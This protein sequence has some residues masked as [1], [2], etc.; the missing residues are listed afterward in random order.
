MDAPNMRAYVES[1]VGQTVYTAV[2]NRPNTIVAIRGNQAIVRTRDGNENPASLLKL[3][4]IADAVW[5]ASGERIHVTVSQSSRADRLTCL[6]RSC[7]RGRSVDVAQQAASAACLV[8]T[9]SSAI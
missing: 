9:V 2:E 6:A 1:L 4:D 5:V 3:Q 7:T 8:A